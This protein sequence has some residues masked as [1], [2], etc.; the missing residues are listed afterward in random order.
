MSGLRRRLLRHY[1]LIITV[2]VVVM[3]MV[4]LLTVRQYYYGSAEHLLRQRVALAASFYGRF[5]EGQWLADRGRSLIDSVNASEEAEVQVLDW[6]GKVVVGSRGFTPDQPIQ[7]ADF[8]TA[9]RGDI[10]SWIGRDELTGERVLAVSSPLMAGQQT[11]GVLRYLVSVEE[12]DG[13]VRMISI[14]S[15]VVGMVVIGL[16]LLFS[17]P[18]VKGIIDPVKE[19]TV[20]ADRLAA[21]Q[22]DVR[23]QSSSDDELGSLAEAFNH[24]ADEIAEADKMKNDFISSISHELRTPLTSIKGW[25]ETIASGDL[26][27]HEETRQGLQIITQET[28]RMIRLVEELL[29]FS[30][31][32]SGRV[33]LYKVLTQINE[34]V[35]QAANQMTIRASA[36]QVELM[37]DL[38]P[39]LGP[40][41]VDID[42]LRQVLINLLDNALK[43]TPEHG[44]IAVR[45]RASG[46]E[47]QIEV[48]DTGS[49]I[50]KEDLPN[51]AKRFYKGASRKAGSGLG[52]SIV[53]EIVRLH[54]GYLRIESD[55]GRGT[56]VI[57]TLPNVEP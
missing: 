51:V 48:V 46:H 11:I 37:L 5:A 40:M 10:G 44:T 16:S 7:T 38:D 15:L 31:I 52:L 42:R 34:L 14:Y 30:R 36:Q 23:A 57:V 21:G 12:I 55:R 2:T 28:D 26:D 29:D 39:G 33:Q 17:L 50:S 32:Q 54:G 53:D 27:N 45:T 20:A 6:S 49:G 56:S 41:R 43:F 25:G 9:M 47:V 13:V 19:L 35:E 18:L 4:F 24:M 3:E 1:G 8:R 22:R